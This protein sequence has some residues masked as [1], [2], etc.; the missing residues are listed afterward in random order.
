M[1]TNR[2]RC[3]RQLPIG[4]PV[5]VFPTAIMSG[6]GRWLAVLAQGQETASLASARARAREAEQQLARVTELHRRG[7]ATN[8]SLDTQTAMVA[9]ARAAANE[10]SASIGDRVVRAP[11]SGQVSLRRISVG[12]DCHGRR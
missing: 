6:R 2:C 9:T 7:F 5:W 12:A 1:R 8:A 11:F 10:A 4:S 3:V